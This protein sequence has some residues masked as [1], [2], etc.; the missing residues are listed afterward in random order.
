MASDDAYEI[1]LDG[2]THTALAT[3]PGMRERTIAVDSMGKTF[4][5]TGWKIGWAIAPPPPSAA[6]RDVHQFVPFCNSTPFQEAA[7]DALEHAHATGYFADLRA[8]YGARRDFL[9]NALAAAGLRTLP[10]AGAYFLLADIGHLP[11]ADD[12]AFC[13]HL[14][15]SVGVA[16]I[17]P[18]AF[19]ADPKTAPKLAR[20]C[21]AKRDSTMQAAAERLS[22]LAVP[23]P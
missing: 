2:A 9:R 3:R 22:R 18:S 12:T 1:L 8:A 11:F 23:N 17:P 5:V 4:S 14:I 16:A 21:F 10:V 19:Y 15:K 20:F 7:A 13:M 6:I